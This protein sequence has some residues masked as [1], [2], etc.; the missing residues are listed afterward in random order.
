M[1]IRG[2]EASRMR[3]QVVRRSTRVWFEWMRTTRSPKVWVKILT[4]WLVRAI[5]GTSK[6]VDFCSESALEAISR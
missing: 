4:N 1:I 2:S 5:S 6:I 3:S